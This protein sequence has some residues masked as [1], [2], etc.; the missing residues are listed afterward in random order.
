MEDIPA[1]LIVN[2]DQTGIKLVPSSSW[3]MDLQG[4][5]RIEISGATDKH[6][7]T[8]VFCGSIVG[9][10]LPLQLIYK[11]E[12]DRCHPQS[13]FPLD[14]DINHASKLGHHP[15]PLTLVH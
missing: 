11:G 15:C 9:E 10:F 8:A 12:T 14:W 5:K 2:W 6:L 1:E 13:K 7:I 4:K 3:T